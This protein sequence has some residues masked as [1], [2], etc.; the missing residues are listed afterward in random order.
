MGY[1]FE[2]HNIGPFKV[3]QY[4]FEVGHDKVTPKAILKVYFKE[5]ILFS[6][7]Y[8][9]TTSDSASR[10]LKAISSLVYSA[11]GMD[12]KQLPLLINLKG[13]DILLARLAKKR[14]IVG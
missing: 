12:F 3:T 11:V 9:L 14:L 7:E 8:L 5:E 1:D 10:Y 6:I 13:Q 4:I 2:E